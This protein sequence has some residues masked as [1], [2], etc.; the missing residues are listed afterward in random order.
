M[1]IALVSWSRITTMKKTARIQVIWLRR[2]RLSRV[3]QTAVAFKFRLTLHAMPGGG[4]YFQPLP[5][6]FL[7]AT[8]ADPVSALLD[9][10]Q[11]LVHFAQPVRL[12]AG[13]VQRG[14]ALEVLRAVL[15]VAGQV[16]RMLRARFV[17]GFLL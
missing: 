16:R 7:L 5:G 6:D 13:Y 14:L 10:L 17:K 1:M 15:G 3:S 12:T 8:F 2:S 9:P 4:E 11:G